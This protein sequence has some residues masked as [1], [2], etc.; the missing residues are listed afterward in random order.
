MKE[1]TDSEKLNIL[2]QRMKRM[3]ISQHIQTGIVIV[4]FLG[5]LSFGALL[6]KVKKSVK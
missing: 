4:G 6:N 5:I 3:E 1:M 2:S